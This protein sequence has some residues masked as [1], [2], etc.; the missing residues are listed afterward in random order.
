MVPPRAVIASV[1]IAVCL[2]QT[3]R[4]VLFDGLGRDTEAVRHLLVG[5]LV[6]YTQCKCRT[7]LGRQ[8]VDSLLYE[9][10]PFVAEQLCLQRLMLGIGPRPAKIPRCVSLHG[11]SMTVFVRSKIARRREKKRSERRHRLALTIGTKKC[12]LDD[13]LARFI[14]PD[15]ALNVAVERLAALGEEPGENLGA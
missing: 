8:P 11:P 12:F 5:T 7:A 15:K 14:R 9:L 6:K 2:A 4:D 1:Q 13:F 10:I 3:A